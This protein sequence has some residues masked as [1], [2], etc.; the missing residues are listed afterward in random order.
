M[1]TKRYSEPVIAI[2]PS[3]RPFCWCGCGREVFAPRLRYA[4]KQC[5]DKF[6]LRSDPSYLR[7]QVWLRDKGICAE[8]GRDTVAQ[9]DRLTELKYEERLRVAAMYCI[10]KHRLR[11]GELWDV[12]HIVPVVQGGGEAGLDNLQTLCLSCHREKTTA[13]AQSKTHLRRVRSEK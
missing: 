3:G 5:R 9:W 6:K 4:T 13:A 8:C 12:D 11:K 10:P 1:S 7:Q 2:A